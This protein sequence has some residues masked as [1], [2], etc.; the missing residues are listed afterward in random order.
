LDSLSSWSSLL[1]LLLGLVWLFFLS[2]ESII[3]LLIVLL[4]CVPQV[5]HAL[6]IKNTTLKSL[7]YNLYTPAEFFLFFN[8]FCA[9]VE[10]K[11]NLLLV[12]ITA[13][14]Y[15]VASVFFILYFNVAKGFISEWAALNNLIYTTWILIVFL[16]QYRYSN[17]KNLDFSSPFF[18]FIM[19]LLFYSPCTAMIFS[20]WNYMEQSNASPLKIIHAIFNINMYLL[21]SIGF[22]KDKQ[23]KAIF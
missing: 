8:V 14:V 15:S 19:G 3:I 5:L 1:P 10:N 13:I 20:M 22:L 7:S 9:H 2:R 11:K 6:D 17:E 4:A 16:E 21:F 18:W 23:L 12:K